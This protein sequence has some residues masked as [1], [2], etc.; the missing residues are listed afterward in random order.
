MSVCF[1]FRVFTLMGMMYAE[2]KHAEEPAKAGTSALY[3]KG[4]TNNEEV[5][6]GKTPINIYY[7]KRESSTDSSNS[8]S[9]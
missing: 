2:R 4:F 5:I 8:S 7:P 9:C 1:L 6:S 3:A